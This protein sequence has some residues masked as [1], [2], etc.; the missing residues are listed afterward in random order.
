MKTYL[1]TL[2]SVVLISL[3]ALG[4]ENNERNIF[5]NEFHLSLNHGIP[6][7]SGKRTFFG[8]GLGASHVFRANRIVGARIGLEADFFHVWGGDTQVPESDKTRRNQH[9]YLTKVSLPVN[10]RITLGKKTRFLFEA[11]GRFGLIVSAYYTADVLQTGPNYET[12][13]EHQ[14]TAHGPVGLGFVGLNSGIGT[15]IPM[16]EKLDL[17]IRPDMGANLYFRE[18]GEV[19]LYTRLCVGIHLK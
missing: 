15:L 7:Y 11:G 4:Q 14:K 17:L 16:N 18:T 19:Y 10:L 8:G 2:V 9:F 6:A 1:V 13:F 3:T 12:F 5:L